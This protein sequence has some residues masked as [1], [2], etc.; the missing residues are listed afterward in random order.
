MGAAIAL[1]ILRRRFVDVPR[2]GVRLAQDINNLTCPT[3]IE[4]PPESQWIYLS[5]SHR[6]EPPR[7]SPYLVHKRTST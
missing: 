2:G 3:F 6:F 4:R 1:E 5:L 7:G